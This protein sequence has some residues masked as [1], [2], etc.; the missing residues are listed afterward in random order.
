MTANSPSN[1]Y[2]P[3]GSSID[4]ISGSSPSR[5]QHAAWGPSQQSLGRRVLA[6]LSTS[7]AA[8][9][10]RPG[11]SQSPRSQQDRNP[12][13]PITNNTLSQSTSLNRQT[14]RS[15]SITSTSSPF[16]PSPSSQQQA[17]LGSLLSS[18]RSRA[19]GPST[20][21][22]TSPGLH[23]SLGIG[24]I[25]SNSAGSAKSYRASPSLPQ[26]GFGSPT[27][28]SHSS[29]QTSAGQSGSLSKIAIAQVFLLLSTMKEDR[30]GSKANQVMKVCCS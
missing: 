29:G 30:D 19:V 2:N 10:A 12:W 24:A 23:G 8:N 3:S 4:R 18:G 9:S 15:S 7:I 27:L 20:T 16:S 21:S 13:S 26:S 17:L 28:P 1:L 11:G 22:Q 5:P 14:A 6:P 25:G